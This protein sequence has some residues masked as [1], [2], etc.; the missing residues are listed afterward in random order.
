MFYN[1]E[2]ELVPG[3]NAFYRKVLDLGKDEFIWREPPTQPHQDVFL[4]GMTALQ[5]IAA[6]LPAMNAVELWA[7]CNTVPTATVPSV[8]ALFPCELYTVYRTD[9][10]VNCRPTDYM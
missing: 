7:Y 10:F 3:N 4:E 2:S 6:P 9:V 5:Y 8:S 1:I